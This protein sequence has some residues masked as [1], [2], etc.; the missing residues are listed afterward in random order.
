MTTSIINPDLQPIVVKIQGGLV[1]DVTGV[2]PGH[3]VIIWDNDLEGLDE[4][5]PQII[6][7]TV[8]G[9]E[10]YQFHDTY[11]ADPDELSV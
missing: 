4:N 1:H 2:P 5:D 10:Y 8:D 9:T 3:Q 11:I 6:T 7:D